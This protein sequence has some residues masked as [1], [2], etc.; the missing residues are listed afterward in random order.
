MTLKTKHDVAVTWQ[1]GTIPYTVKVPAGTPVR[2]AGYNNQDGPVYRARNLHS[3]LKPDSIE[4][5][6]AVHYGVCID[7]KDVHETST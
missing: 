4:M 5:H 7:A 6:D 1:H 2:P 3:F